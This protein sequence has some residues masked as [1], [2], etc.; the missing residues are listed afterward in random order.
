MNYL[1]PLSIAVL[2][3]LAAIMLAVPSPDGWIAVG[4]SKMVR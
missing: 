4:P 1:I 2:A 3:L